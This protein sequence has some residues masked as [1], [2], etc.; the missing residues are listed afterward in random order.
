MNP[1]RLPCSVSR[2]S[3]LRFYL[4]PSFFFSPSPLSPWFS[5]CAKSVFLSPSLSVSLFFSYSRRFPPVPFFSCSPFHCQSLTGVPS[6]LTC[7]IS[8]TESSPQSSLFITH[9]P[10][11][12]LISPAL[13]MCFWNPLFIFFPLFACSLVL[14]L[15][16]PWHT[17]THPYWLIQ[18]FFYYPKTKV[19][20]GSLS[21]L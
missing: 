3:P 18:S 5:L 19:I 10:L 11:P 2:L 6:L 17:R 13:F 8:H 14:S 7:S 1:I 15:T 20:N 21:S 9:F 16:H 12:S 4:R